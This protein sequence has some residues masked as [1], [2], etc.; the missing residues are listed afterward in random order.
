MPAVRGSATAMDKTGRYAY[1][2]R[3]PTITIPAY[4]NPVKIR[5]GPA[6]VIGM[7]PQPPLFSRM[8]RRGSRK[9]ESQ[10]TGRD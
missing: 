8:G 4:G 2:R 3:S 5:N 6:T 7:K 1:N 9:T 10:E